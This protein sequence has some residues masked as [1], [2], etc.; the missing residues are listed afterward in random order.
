MPMIAVRRGPMV[1]VSR[2]RT[3]RSKAP[4]RSGRATSMPF[5]T[6]RQVEIGDDEVG[7]GAEHHPDHETYI[8]VKKR[9]EQRRPVAGPAKLAE[10]HSS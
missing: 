10:I 2:P 1:S 8:E 7:Q 3:S 9:T 4:L 5:C 6:G